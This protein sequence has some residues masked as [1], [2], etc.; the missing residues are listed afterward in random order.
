MEQEVWK[1]GEYK[2]DVIRR[3]GV[4]AGR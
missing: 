3:D 4:L 1:H 2:G